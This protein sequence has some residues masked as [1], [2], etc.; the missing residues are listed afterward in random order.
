[1]LY[2]SILDAVEFNIVALCLW[3]RGFYICLFIHL[4]LLS[5]SLFSN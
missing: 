3:F 4:V 5:L 1:M 2:M